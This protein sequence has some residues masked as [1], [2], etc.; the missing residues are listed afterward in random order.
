MYTIDTQPDSASISFSEAELVLLNN[1]LN[2]VLNGMEISE[3]KL[4]LALHTQTQINFFISLARFS[5]E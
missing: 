5:I 1:C 4:V 2:E 3:F